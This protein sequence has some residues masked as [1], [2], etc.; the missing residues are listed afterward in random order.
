MVNGDH[1]IGIFAKRPI[2]PGEELFF[3]YRLLINL[4][5]LL[6]CVKCLFVIFFIIFVIDMD[7]L[8]SLNLLE[9]RE[10]WNFYPNVFEIKL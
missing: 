7:Q 2:Q 1:R 9:L 8:N 4:Y 5:F 3:D 6:M 10:R